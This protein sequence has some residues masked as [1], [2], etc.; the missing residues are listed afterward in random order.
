MSAEAYVQ[1]MR[2]EVKDRSGQRTDQCGQKG[3][4]HQRAGDQRPAKA[5]LE[6]SDVVEEMQVVGREA[7]DIRVEVR[8]HQEGPE[9]SAHVE[10]AD[11]RSDQARNHLMSSAP[12]SSTSA[13]WAARSSM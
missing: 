6:G 1:D 5:D 4:T 10:G 11:D 12:F 9:S 3:A 2:Q 13:T 7:R 8:G